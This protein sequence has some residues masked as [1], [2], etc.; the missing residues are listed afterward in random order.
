MI[1]ARALIGTICCLLQPRSNDWTAASGA[2]CVLRS[3]SG[4][5]ANCGVPRSRAPLQRGLCLVAAV[6]AGADRVAEVA[7]EGA[8][9]VGDAGDGLAD[10]VV[11]G[12]ARAFGGAVADAQLLAELG[13]EEASSSRVRWARARSHRA[14][15]S[16]RASRSSL[17]RWRYARRLSASSGV[18]HSRALPLTVSPSGAA[19]SPCRTL[20]VWAISSSTWS[21]RPAFAS[22]TPR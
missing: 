7:A 10:A 4:A 22:S 8:V 12:L 19:D 21:S 2:S 3:S 9:L 14:S 13:L 16:H 5:A 1:S 15:A 6:R 11:D 17:A 20:S 18:S